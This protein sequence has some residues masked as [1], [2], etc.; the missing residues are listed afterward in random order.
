MLQTTMSGNSLLSGENI[1]TKG[2][3]CKAEINNNLTPMWNSFLVNQSQLPSGWDASRVL[4][5]TRKALYWKENP[6]P[7]V[8][9]TES[10]DLTVPAKWVPMEWG[11]FQIFGAP[12]PHLYSLQ[13]DPLLS[14]ATG[15]GP[16]STVPV[17][18]GA[19]VSV[20]S[21]RSRRTIAA[22]NTQSALDRGATTRMA[23][24]P[25]NTVDQSILL[26]TQVQ[27]RQM[28]YEERREVVENLKML[29]ELADNEVEKSSYTGRLKRYLQDVVE[30]K[31][32]ELAAKRRRVSVSEVTDVTTLSSS[33][34]R[35][36]T[37]RGRSLS[38][39]SSTSPTSPPPAI[40]LTPPIVIAAT[41]PIINNANIVPRTRTLGTR[42]NCVT[43]ASDRSENNE[44]TSVL[45]V[46]V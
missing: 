41:A 10:E 34:F 43:R 29:I 35:T 33:T 22:E 8:G 12:C 4:E 40:S 31:T 9:D 18:G 46:D 32:E 16:I 45:D 3:A 37:P 39:P 38:I 15:A 2:K 25:L 23:T 24:R 17:D 11:A 14:L 28:D 6:A 27:G 20:S 30:D 21:G 26:Q 1:Y 5:E 44:G 7:V 13:I 42:R 36:P 19:A